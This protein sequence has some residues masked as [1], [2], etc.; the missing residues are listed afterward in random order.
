MRAR[1][2]RGATTAGRSR[3]PS[4]ECHYLAES[5]RNL[6]NALLRKAP[7]SLLDETRSY[8]LSEFYHSL[9]S[10]LTEAPM[11]LISSRTASRWNA[12]SSISAERSAFAF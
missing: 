2:L 8:V 11:R 9:C 6:E 5:T 3:R 12:N 10:D 7:I 4:R 1:N